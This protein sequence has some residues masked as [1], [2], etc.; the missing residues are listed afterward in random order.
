LHL[1]KGIDRARLEVLLGG[2]E[3][4]GEGERFTGRRGG[5]EVRDDGISR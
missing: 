3:R 2:D 4:E 1:A 5:G